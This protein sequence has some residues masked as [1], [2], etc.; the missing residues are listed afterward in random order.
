VRFGGG[1]LGGRRAVSGAAWCGWHTRPARAPARLVRARAGAARGRRV[2]LRAVV[3]E[4]A[5]LGTARALI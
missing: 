5:V 4:R 2:E 3:G 1:W